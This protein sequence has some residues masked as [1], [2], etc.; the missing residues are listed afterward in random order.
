LQNRDRL[1][2]ELE[3]ITRKRK[4]AEWIELL[5]EAGVPCGPI[6]R[7]DEVFADPQVRHIGIARA[8]DDSRRGPRRLVGQAVEL[9][10]TP[11]RLRTAA[12]EKGEHTA[13]VLES[14]GYDARAIADLRSRGVI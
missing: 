7:I 14:L 13:A 11:W 9:S 4:S 1:N 12:P 3:T 5:N 10:R 6:Y 8:I 2:A